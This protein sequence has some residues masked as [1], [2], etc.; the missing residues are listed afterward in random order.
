MVNN[1]I[2]SMLARAVHEIIFFFS[3]FYFFILI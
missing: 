3:I 2:T 1:T